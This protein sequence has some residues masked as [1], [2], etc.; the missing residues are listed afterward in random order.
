MESIPAAALDRP[1]RGLNLQPGLLRDQLGEGLHLLVF[2]RHFGCIFCRETV[3]DLRR[4]AGE[5]PDYPPVLFF[6]QGT[7]IE[8]KAFLRRFWPEARAVCDPELAFYDDFGVGRAGLVKALGPK[9]LAARG[10]ARAKGLEN[11]PRSGD[12]WRMPGVFA[13]RDERV[14]WRYEPSHAADHPDFAAI[15]EILADA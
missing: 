9:V 6:S 1:V 14:V 8:A 10:R 11:G 5:S 3:T 7:P 12:I 13:V 2:L 15:P 4:I